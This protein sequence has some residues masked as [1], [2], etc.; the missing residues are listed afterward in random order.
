MPALHQ[1]LATG[2]HICRVRLHALKDYLGMVELLR[3]YPEV[4]VTFNLVPSLLGSCRR[5]VRRTDR[6]WRSGWPAGP[7]PE[8]ESSSSATGSM[9]PIGVIAPY[10]RYLELFGG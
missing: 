5:S 10:P 9:R 7:R 3:A 2:E 4:H 1:I 6:H 8:D